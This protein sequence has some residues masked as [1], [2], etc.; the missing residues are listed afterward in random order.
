MMLGRTASLGGGSAGTPMAW[1]GGG[2][3]TAMG[4]GPG[5]GYG[6]GAGAGYGGGA[7]QPQL[8][9]TLHRHLQNVQQLPLQQHRLQQHPHLAVSVAVWLCVSVCIFVCVIERVCVC[10]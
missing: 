3:V 4:S 1:G 7:G 2:A 8:P 10:V 9:A 6:G 5:V